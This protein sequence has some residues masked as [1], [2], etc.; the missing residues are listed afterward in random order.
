MGK[1]WIKG[2]QEIFNAPLD[3][4]HLEDL[5]EA[6]VGFMCQGPDCSNRN[7]LISTGEDS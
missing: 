7:V 2:Q 1:G 6:Y 4:V 3:G 5:K